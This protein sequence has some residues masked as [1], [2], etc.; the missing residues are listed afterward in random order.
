MQ[1]RMAVVPLRTAPKQH[2]LFSLLSNNKTANEETCEVG[3]R[4]ASI[5]IGL[6]KK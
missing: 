3:P 2:I 1:F 6:D 4:V 5:A